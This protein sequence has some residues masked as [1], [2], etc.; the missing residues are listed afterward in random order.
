M[1]KSDDWFTDAQSLGTGE[2]SAKTVSTKN[3]AKAIVQAFRAPRAGGAWRSLD[4]KQVADRLDRLIDD[5]RLFNQ[6]QLNLCGPASF[7][8]VWAQRDPKAFARFATT[9]FDTG[10]A[11]INGKLAVHPSDALRNQDYAAMRAKMFS[12]TEQ[13][14][15]MVMGAL[16]NNS[17]ALFV[18]DGDPD[19]KMAGIT[20]PD[21]II[22]WMNA[23]GL[24]SSVDN[25]VGN[26]ATSL[27]SKGYQAAENLPIEGA[28]IICLIQANMVAK[29]INAGTAPGFLACFPNHWI[30]L[31][32]PVQQLVTNKR[33]TFPLWSFGKD[34][35]DLD[36]DDAELFASSY[37]GS[38]VGLLK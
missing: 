35:T 12:I 18:W 19:Q 24:Y 17:D 1:N 31:R 23:T 7:C 10:A 5:P 36:V 32:G 15:W 34:W 11:S 26:R 3:E 37:Y 25:Q 38:I 9:L 13:A 21:E 14:D 2:P 27:S 8:T 30:V 6:G 33:V 22:A 20:F 28:D 4:R 16:R 29:R